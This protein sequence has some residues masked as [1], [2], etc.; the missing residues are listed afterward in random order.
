MDFILQNVGRRS[1]QEPIRDRRGEIC[2]YRGIIL[3]KPTEP[4]LLRGFGHLTC[5]CI[6][7]SH[8]LQKMV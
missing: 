7:A 5:R 8:Q 4:D 1:L 3:G 2:V 6:S